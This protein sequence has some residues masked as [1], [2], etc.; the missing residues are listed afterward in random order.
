MFPRRSTLLLTSILF[1]A[2]LSCRPS[3]R[4]ADPA[5][6]RPPVLKE[7]RLILG[8]DAPPPDGFKVIGT[9]VNGG[10]LYGVQLA[11]KTEGEDSDY[12]NVAIEL[13]SIP[14]DAT[15]LF[16]LAKTRSKKKAAHFQK[17]LDN[18][19]T[20]AFEMIQPTPE[21]HFHRG[22]ALIVV[23]GEKSGPRTRQLARTL[24]ERIIQLQNEARK[25]QPPVQP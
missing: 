16:Q 2:T 12:L 20:E 21:V 23:T 6:T 4:T 15:S 3:A 24:D 13:F 1:L 9:T 10:G 17:T 8:E 19:G 7:H 25:T 18:L 14:S 11:W 5:A 22:N